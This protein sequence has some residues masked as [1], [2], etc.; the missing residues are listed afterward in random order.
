MV[1]HIIFAWN[2]T[3][4]IDKKELYIFKTRNTVLLCKN[5]LIELQPE[6][7]AETIESG[8]LYITDLFQNKSVAYFY[9]IFIFLTMSYMFFAYKYAMLLFNTV[10]KT[11]LK[12]SKKSFAHKKLKKTTPKSCILMAVGSFSFSL[13]P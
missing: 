10:A 4:T 11:F 6:T 12:E 1:H 5:D 9:F 3:L 2:M 13:Q 7:L 8:P